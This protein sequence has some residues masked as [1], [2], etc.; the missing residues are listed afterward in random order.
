MRQEIIDALSKATAEEERLLLGEGHVDQKIYTASEEFIVDSRMLTDGKDIIV[1]KHTRFAD[2]PEHGHDYIE[3]MYVCKGT[4]THCI[5]GEKVIL[6]QGD[7]LFLNRYARHSIDRAEKDDIAINIITTAE[8]IDGLLSRMEKNEIFSGF[9][10]E[11]LRQS[12]T[13]Q[14]LKFSVRGNV[15]IENLLESLLYEL[16]WQGLADREIIV[17]TMQLLLLYLS[18]YPEVLVKS[19]QGGQSGQLAAKISG[20]L[21]NNYRTASLTELASL[22]GVTPSYASRMVS[23]LL[24]ASFQQLL[25]ERRLAVAETLLINSDLTVSDII[26]AVGYLNTGFFHRQFKARYGCSPLKWRNQHRAEQK[27]FSS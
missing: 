22:L 26:F 19:R 4:V 25:S 24:G 6:S 15:S 18:H 27:S 5:D 10:L 13:S 11:N 9:L 2:F 16:V 20:Y 12:G 14:Y 1:R 7:L 23:R 3:I 21:Q 17:Q 8:F